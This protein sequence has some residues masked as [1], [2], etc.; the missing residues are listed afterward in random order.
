MFFKLTLIYTILM[1]FKL[2]LIYTNVNKWILP[3]TKNAF[4]ILFGVTVVPENK[5]FKTAECAF[6]CFYCLIQ[7]FMS[8]IAT[9]QRNRNFFIKKTKFKG[10]MINQYR[11]N[12]CISNVYDLFKSLPSHWTRLRISSGK[13][14]LCLK[15][16]V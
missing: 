15:L 4:S 2:N 8:F 11:Q 14:S 13:L 10:N 1:S 9:T 5:P 7:V 3:F 16:M 6:R 12:N